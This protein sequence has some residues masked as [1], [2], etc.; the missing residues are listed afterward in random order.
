MVGGVGD[1]R[2]HVRF[3]GLDDVGARLQP[4]QDDGAGDHDRIAAE[5]G[6]VVVVAMIVV[7]DDGSA[8]ED[9]LQQQRERDQSQADSPRHRSTF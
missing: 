6:E 7:D 8:D 1:A 9:R 2:G 4:R 5:D 3:R